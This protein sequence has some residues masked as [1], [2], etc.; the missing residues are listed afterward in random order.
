MY[1]MNIPGY[2]PIRCDIDNKT[3]SC[4]D[5]LLATGVSEHVATHS[6]TCIF[7]DWTFQQ[8]TLWVCHHMRVK[9]FFAEMALMRIVPSST[10]ETFLA[11]HAVAKLNR[12]VT[13]TS[14]E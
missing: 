2:S 4:K 8:G 3:V 14:I 9:H 11:R 12:T 5:L 13:L 7:S 6:V 10:V 1:L